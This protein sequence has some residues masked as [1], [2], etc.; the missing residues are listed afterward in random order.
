MYNEVERREDWKTG[1][2]E[3]QEETESYRV[4]EKW[5]HGYEEKKQEAGGKKE[6][7][8]KEWQQ[9]EKVGKRED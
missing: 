2:E 7:K 6:M 8:D 3:R 5:S 9:N 1:K 4:G